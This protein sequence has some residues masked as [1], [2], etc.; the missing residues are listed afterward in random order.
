MN[1]IDNSI[2][3]TD[4]EMII[5]Q[6]IFQKFTQEWENIGISND[7][8]FCKIMQDEGL[9]S[10]LLRR[11]LPDLKIKK[12]YI[13]PQKSVEV[14]MDIHGVRFDIFAELEDGDTVVIEMQVKDTG[15]LPKRLR[16]YGSL[17]DTQM[18]E[19]GIVYSKLK[20]SYI[21]LICK[22]DQYGE[23]RHIYT[24]TNRCVESPG[25]EMG[26]GT[27]KIVL[28]AVGTMDD[29]SDNLRAVLDYIAGKPS[30]DEYVKKLDNEVKKARA[31]KEWRREYMVGWMRDLENQEIWIEKGIEIGTE[32][33][34]DKGRNIRDREKIEN[35]LKKG[36]TPQDIADFCD[37]PIELILDVQN[38]LMEKV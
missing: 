8:V 30:E 6:E 16:F 29:I 20:D 1:N 11:I 25:L 19:K 21:I 36:K 12:L 9:L 37:Y 13:Q 7:F 35:M 18:L 26:D 14:G 17:S 34:I 24:F 10:E 38:G 23:G 31:N 33:G 32:R 2:H 27:K 15:N 4:D 3:A 5:S 22:F 28:N